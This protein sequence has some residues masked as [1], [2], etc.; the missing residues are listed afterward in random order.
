LVSVEYFVLPKIS[1]GGEFGW[2]LGFVSQGA[3]SL[4]QVT[5]DANGNVV[6]TTTDGPTG[7]DFSLDTDNAGGAL[8]INFHF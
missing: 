6:T 2:G 7:S 3:G 8:M 4:T 1:I 5:E